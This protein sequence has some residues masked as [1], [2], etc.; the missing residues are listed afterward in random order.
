MATW[1]E[2]ERESAQ[3][4]REQN[5]KES[6]TPLFRSKLPLKKVQYDSMPEDFNKWR[7]YKFRVP[8][9]GVAEDEARSSKIRRVEDIIDL[10]VQRA[11]KM[12]SWIREKCIKASSWSMEKCFGTPGQVEE[13]LTWSLTKITASSVIKYL[14]EALNVLEW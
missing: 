11:A 6:P 14:E 1:D 4:H 8:C 10:E 2:L 12:C 7:Q 13:F 3:K 9:L 5:R